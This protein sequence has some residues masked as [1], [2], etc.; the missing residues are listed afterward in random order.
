MKILLS[1]DHIYS[2][3]GQKMPGV[4]EIMDAAGIIDKRWY[5]ERACLRGTYVHKAVELYHTTG[6]NLNSLDSEVAP[7]FNG[8]M[9]FLKDSDF[10]PVI[11]EKLSYSPL[12]MYCGTPDLIGY[13]NGE[14][15][16]IDIKSGNIPK[17]AAIQT[18]AY[19]ELFGNTIEGKPITKRMALQ[20]KANGRY[21]LKIYRS[22]LDL[23]VFLAA[24]TVY[25][26]KHGRL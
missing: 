4:S 2:V 10:K 26:F 24:L 6:L 14:L 1:E 12:Y 5:N 13:L 21:N 11:V 25:N 18:A 22:R 8:Y 23:D 19:K 9:E 15:V 20:L 16:L 17:W 3:D 7:F